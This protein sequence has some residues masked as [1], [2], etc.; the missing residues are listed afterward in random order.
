MECELSISLP[1][2]LEKLCSLLD[3]SKVFSGPRY[4]GAL[5][6]ASRAT[7]NFENRFGRVVMPPLRLCPFNTWNSLKR[8]FVESQN[9]NFSPIVQPT[10]ESLY[11]LYY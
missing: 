6:S 3:E 7:F 2:Y 9:R 4:G 10:S 11:R 8:Q 5:V 1:I